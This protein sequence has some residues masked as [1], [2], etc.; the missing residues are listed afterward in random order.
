MLFILLQ[1]L[2]YDHQY[3]DLLTRLLNAESLSD[4]PVCPECGVDDFVDVE[5]FKLSELSVE[6][7]E[8]IPP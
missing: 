4:L 3:G 7:V 2:S 1:H 6:S 5:R 8:K